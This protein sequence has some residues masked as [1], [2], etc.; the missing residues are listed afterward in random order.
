MR[1]LS[2]SD[3]KLFER[4]VSLSQKELKKAM[5]QYLKQNMKM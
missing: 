5:A 4:L 2:D 3:Y 1:V